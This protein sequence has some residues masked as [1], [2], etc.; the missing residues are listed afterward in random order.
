MCRGEQNRRRRILVARPTPLSAGSLRFEAE[1]RE[2]GHQRVSVL[3]LN[4]DHTVFHGA[5]D[6]AP[7]FQLCRKLLD[8]IRR[9]W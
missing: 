3:A 7:L 1:F 9:Q 6:A 2:F 4:L 8:V 5:A